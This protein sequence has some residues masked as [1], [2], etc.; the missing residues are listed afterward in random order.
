VVFFIIILIVTNFK[1]FRVSKQKTLRNL[2]ISLLL[3]LL[4]QS[5]YILPVLD[6]RAAMII[7]GAVVSTSY[8]HFYYIFLELLKVILLGVFT[9]YTLIGK[10]RK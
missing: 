1:T 8:F 10:N 5:L 7:D 4:L 9:Q 6:Q 3:I 2:L